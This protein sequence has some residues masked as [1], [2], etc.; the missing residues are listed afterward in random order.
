MPLF[1]DFERVEVRARHQNEGGFDYMNASERRGIE[2]IR[3]LLESWFEHLP[4]DA[5]AD[6]SGRFRPREEAQHES[7]FFELYWHELLTHCGCE[8]EIHAALSDVATNPDFLALQSQVPQFYLEATLAMPPGD[9]AADRRFAELHDTNCNSL[10]LVFAAEQSAFLPPALVCVACTNEFAAHPQNVPWNGAE[11][12]RNIRE[13]NQFVTRYL[14]KD[15]F[16]ARHTFFA[17]RRLVELILT[18]SKQEN[19]V[20]PDDEVTATVRISPHRR[21]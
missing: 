3:E 18:A 4:P 17:K 5:Q 11:H 9:P 14:R 10:P 13:R 19:L 20:S 8:L 6:V 1:D 15:A 16:S 7:A 2:A 21:K 12:F